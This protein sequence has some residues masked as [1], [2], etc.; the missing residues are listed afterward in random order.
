[1]ASV[2]V[3]VTDQVIDLMTDVPGMRLA[4]DTK[5]TLQNKSNYILRIM[6]AVAEPVASSEAAIAGAL[7]VSSLESIVFEIPTGES[8]YAWYP[9]G[10]SGTLAIVEAS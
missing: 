3:R 1:M 5:Y 7:L 4:A 9:P 10:Q 6:Q 2:G 8:I